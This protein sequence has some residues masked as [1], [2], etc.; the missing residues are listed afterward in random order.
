MSE[1]E[2]WEQQWNRSQIGKVMWSEGEQ[3]T[4]L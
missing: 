4:D 2:I 1:S 3:V